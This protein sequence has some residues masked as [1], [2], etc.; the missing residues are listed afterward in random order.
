[1][2][3]PNVIWINGAFGVGKTAVARELAA[4]IPNAHVV[5]PELIGYV[6][7]RLPFA[8]RRDY[9]EFQAWRLLTRLLIRVA[10]LRGT[11][12]VPMTVVSPAVRREV[13]GRITR[14]RV[15]A[16]T[17]SRSTLEGR[18][19]GSG[20]AQSWRLANLDCCLA[21]LDDPHLGEHID[22][23]NALPGE[24]AERIIERL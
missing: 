22:S 15:F 19:A 9:Q 16:L 2:P 17:A 23:E 13:I 18:I 10:A 4:R 1:M 24:L 14:I 5:D 11:V 6:L 20:V 3:A 8:P 12:I 7:R 21:A